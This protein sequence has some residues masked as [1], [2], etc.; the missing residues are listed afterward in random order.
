MLYGSDS[1][2]STTEVLTN[3]RA[4]TNNPCCTVLVDSGHSTTEAACTAPS[5][6]PTA[7]KCLIAQRSLVNQE[8]PNN[9][10]RA[11][12]SSL[13]RFSHPSTKILT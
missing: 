6:M 3:E 5:I 10:S 1:G 11:F 9:P 12:I 7:L 8:K 2:H 13:T 4:N